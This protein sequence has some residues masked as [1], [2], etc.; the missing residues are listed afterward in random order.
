MKTMFE[1]NEGGKERHEIA[2]EI[3]RRAAGSCAAFNA[4]SNEDLLMADVEASLCWIMWRG[5][6]YQAPRGAERNRN[7]SAFEEIGATLSRMLHAHD[8]QD[9]N[10]Q[11]NMQ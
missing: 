8:I 11:R 6:R 4:T 7:F 9:S 5:T 2:E 10:K 3:K 1:N